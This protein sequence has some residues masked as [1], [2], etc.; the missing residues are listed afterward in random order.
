LTGMWTLTQ[1]EIE[2]WLEKK[3]LKF[4]TRENKNPI[5]DA[6]IWLPNYVHFDLHEIFFIEFPIIF[7]EWLLR[8]CEGNLPGGLTDQESGLLS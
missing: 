1:K 7:S 8:L 4:A 5:C 6:R 3:E 2:E